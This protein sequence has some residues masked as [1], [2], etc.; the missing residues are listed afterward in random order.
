MGPLFYITIPFP[1]IEDKASVPDLPLINLLFT[2]IHRAAHGRAFAVALPSMQPGER[3]D[4]GQ[5]MQVFSPER[6]VLEYLLTNPGVQQL[7]RD[8]FLGTPAILPVPEKRIIGWARYV[9]DR[10][11]DKASPARLRRQAARAAKGIRTQPIGAP[12]VRPELPYFHHVSATTGESP[13]IFVR[14]EDAEGPG[15]FLFDSF[16]LSKGGAVP[17]LRG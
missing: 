13:R 2:R 15:A 17:V 3:P 5:T 6:E 12:S 9:R 14:R 7:L 1:R 10:R 8:Q 4:I 16:G 11:M